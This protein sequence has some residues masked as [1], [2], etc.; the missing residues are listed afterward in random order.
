MN[1]LNLLAKNAE[2]HPDAI[3]IVHGQDTRTFE[4]LYKVTQQAATGMR[5]LGVSR[6]DRIAVFLVSIR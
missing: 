1:L 5:G 2:R 6:N 3:A 4:E